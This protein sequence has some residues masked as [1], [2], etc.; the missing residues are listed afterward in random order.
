[1]E[2]EWIKLNLLVAQKQGANNTL[3]QYHGFAPLRNN[4]LA[5]GNLI[6]NATCHKLLIFMTRYPNGN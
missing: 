6:L 3:K 4:M 1:M 5:S 2:N